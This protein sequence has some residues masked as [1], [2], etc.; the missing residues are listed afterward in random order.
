MRRATFAVTV[1]LLFG[2]AQSTPP[3]AA[4]PDLKAQIDAYNAAWSAAANRGDAAAVVAMYTEKATMLPPGMD[5]QK[6][7]AAT[8]KTIAAIGGSGRPELRPHR[9]R[10][11][12]GGAGYRAGDRPVHRPGAG[13]EKTPGD[14]GGQIPRDL[15]AGRRQT[16]AECRYLEPVQMT[17]WSV[18]PWNL[19]SGAGARIPRAF[20]RPGQSPFP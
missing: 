4:A 3:P 9:H 8:E 16:A 6:G 17:A 11:V 18:V 20:D 2:C 5:I 13:P 14:A 19:T 15:E 1:L 12:P 10:R 7:R